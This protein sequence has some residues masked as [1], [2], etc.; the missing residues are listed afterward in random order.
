MGASA[1]TG[2]SAGPGP[3]QVPQSTPSHIYRPSY[4]GLGATPQARGFM[5]SLLGNVGYGNQRPTF[6]RP[7]MQAPQ[8]SYEVAFKPSYQQQPQRM[9]RQPSNLAEN[10]RSGNLNYDQYQMM[11]ANPRLYTPFARSVQQG[12]TPDTIGYQ[13]PA[14]QYMTQ[15]QSDAYN[16]AQA[17]ELG[18]LLGPAPADP[19]ASDGGG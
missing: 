15:A 16:R 8:R 12:Q 2:T 3:I 18:R 17:A 9:P 7:M 11:M 10:I 13:R 6:T 14:M 4:G 1:G 5:S 19:S